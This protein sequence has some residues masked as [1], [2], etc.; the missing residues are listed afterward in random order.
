MANIEEE[1]PNPLGLRKYQQ[2]LALKAVEG[3][4]CIIVAPTGSGKAHVAMEIIRVIWKFLHCSCCCP[5]VCSG[6]GTVGQ[7][8]FFLIV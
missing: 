8:K 7:G 2:E 6:C 5:P 4:S 1:Q 3:K